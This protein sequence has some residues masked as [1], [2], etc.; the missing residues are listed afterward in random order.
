MISTREVAISSPSVG[1][2]EW[3]AVRAPLVSG[4][5]T[6]GPK[7][8]EFEEAFAERHR[9]THAV[10]TTSCTTA[11]HLALLALGI[12]PGDEVV[13]PAF[14]WIATAQAVAYCGATP[15]FV[16]V[17][18]DTYNMDPALIPA[19]LGPRTR[20]V[21]AVHLA[22]QCADVDAIRSQMPDGMPL[23]EDA[24]CAAGAS[25]RGRP[26]GSLGDVACFSFHPRK[27]ITTGE[28]G[29]LTTDDAGIAA[30]A[31]RLRSHGAAAAAEDRATSSKPYLLPEFDELG[32]NYRMTD[33]QAAIGL[34]QLAKLD[35]FI[36]E[37]A[38]WAEWYADVLAD[39]AWLRTPTSAADGGHSWQSYITVVDQRS[40][41]S[42]EGIMQILHDNGIATRP[43]THAVTELAYYRKNLGLV[44]GQF[45]VASELA[46]RSLALPLH[47]R[48]DKADLEQVSDGLHNIA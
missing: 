14:T 19:A 7:V 47:N 1:D 4:W 35:G 11:L 27:T 29:M 6:Q 24:A 43:G 2:E 15:V 28:G 9:V 21:V 44:P 39:L 23:V 45:P 25:Y 22:G 3:E 20:A 13:V 38:R 26:A 16:D 10:A 33:L 42:R 41:S 36:E 37:R 40:P 30:L 34:V 5:L 46:A 17:L 12:G 31:R 48:L 8:R 32:F 18:P